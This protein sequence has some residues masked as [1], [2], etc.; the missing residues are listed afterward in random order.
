MPTI[1]FPKD[2]I[3]GSATAAYQIEGAY[4]EDGRGESIWD[5]FSHTPGNIEN[6]H[7]GDIACDHYHRYEEDIKIMKE[8]GIKSYR[9]SISWPRIFPEGTGQPNQ[10]GLDFY[11]RLTNLLLENG[12]TP[13]ITL[14]HWDLPQKLQDK[15]GWK[16]RDTTDYF[17]EYSEEIFKNL[18][19]I[20]PIWIT[21]NEPRVVSLLG[22]FLGI[23]APGI[24]DLRT[25]LEVSHHLMLSHGKAVKLFREMNI[26]GQIGIAPNLSYH[27][28]ASQKPEDIAA[29]ELSFSI[30]ARWYLDPLFKGSYPEDALEHYKNKG[31]ELSFSQDDLK[32]I[33]Q[34]M[35][36]LAFNNYSSSF[37]KYDPTSESGYTGADSIVENFEKTDMGWIVYPEGLYDLLMLLD[38]DYGKPNLIISENGAAFKDEISS[39]GRIEDI[40]RTQYLKDYLTQAHRAIQDGVNLKGYYL[41]SFMDNFE[42]AY[43]YNKKFGIVHVDLETQERKIKDSGYWYKE[44]IKNNGF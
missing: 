11:K 21:Q 44:V 28:P 20:V 17:A 15:G 22:H 41:W 39:N 8:I 26:N 37:I 6:G 30:D 24:K 12:I 27:Y 13:A 36:F 23:H 19:D 16:N 3:W 14:Y 5:R 33:S 42:W 18:G 1:N 4:N 35:D 10:K 31:I 38:R 34:P 32:L 25:S 29:T 40:K 9:F 7:T 2:F 43:G